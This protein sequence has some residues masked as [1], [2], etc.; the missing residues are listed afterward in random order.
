MVTQIIA[1][2][3]ALSAL[4]SEP[5]RETLTNIK[6]MLESVGNDNA[7]LR[8]KGDRLK[9]GPAGI[10]WLLNRARYQDEAKSAAAYFINEGHRKITVGTAIVAVDTALKAIGA[11]SESPLLAGSNSVL[12]NAIREIFVSNDLKQPNAE[13]LEQLKEL[14][15]EM[16]GVQCS[17]ANIFCAPSTLGA[18]EVS[19]SGHVSFDSYGFQWVIGSMSNEIPNVVKMDLLKLILANPYIIDR[20]VKQFNSDNFLKNAPGATNSSILRAFRFSQINLESLQLEWKNLD[21]LFVEGSKFNNSN[22]S[23]SSFN[24]CVVERSALNN[25]VLNNTQWQGAKIIDSSFDESSME[26]I[27]FSKAN[28]RGASFK[29]SSL[30]EANLSRASLIGVNFTGS[31]LSRAHLRELPGFRSVNFNSATL[32]GANVTLSK[33][34]LDYLP[35]L[36]DYYINHLNNEGEGLLASINS[37]DVKYAS[38]RNS[39]MKS[40]IVELDKL[41]PEELTGSWA[42]LGDILLKEPSYADDTTIAKFIYERLLPHW[43]AS[44]SQ[45]PLHPEEFDLGMVLEYLTRADGPDWSGPEYQGAVNQLLY[46]ASQSPAQGNL[47]EQANQLRRTYL[48]SPALRVACAT[49]EDFESGLAKLTY[50]FSDASGL[51]VVALEPELFQ[52]LVTPADSGVPAEI[53]WKSLYPMSRATT[54]EL[55][56][57]VAIGNLEQVFVGSPFLKARYHALMSAGSAEALV[58][59][60]FTGSPY[61]DQFIAALACQS[62]PEKL[63]GVEHQSRL[64]AHFAPLW[65]AVSGFELWAPVVEVEEGV[66]VDNWSKASLQLT[67]AHQEAL[68]QAT[69][70]DAARVGGVN[71]FGLD[72]TAVD[73]ASLMLVLATLFTRY[74]SSALFGEEEDSPQAV[75]AYAYALL[76]EA[77]KLDSTLVN[78]DTLKDWRARLSGQAF[79]CTAVLSD[80]MTRHIQDQA[81]PNSPLELVFLGLYPAA[82]R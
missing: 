35:Q 76:Q 61:K 25:V 14:L 62:V 58:E 24:Q 79:S 5:P 30:I 73:R 17:G 43:M 19:E 26:N 81:Q 67:P 53:P 77:H 50:V 47:Q 29:N 60:V 71:R 1:T 69:Y 3:R 54:S 49:L 48:N 28:L 11:P 80:M 38:V 46:A 64:E 45:A 10:K 15:V 21:G 68:W 40:V 22:F 36:I 32:E 7:V 39:L 4:G 70:S 51:A 56:E 65:Q 78:A 2:P 66:K 23:D 41:P 75:R 9:V 6:K 18:A 37:I 42:S 57:N 44:K 27:N 12:D 8:L 55:F 33:E 82:W 72:D 63:T 20:P 16:R 59:T 34:F 13:I 31:D 52:H 74:S